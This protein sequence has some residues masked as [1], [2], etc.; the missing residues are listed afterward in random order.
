MRHI[1]DIDIWRGLCATLGTYMCLN[2]RH[3][4][5]IGWPHVSESKHMVTSFATIC[6]CIIHYL[7]PMT[8]SS[9]WYRHICPHLSAMADICVCIIHWCASLLAGSVWY[10][11]I[12]SHTLSLCLA[13]KRVLCT[14]RPAYMNVIHAC[15]PTELRVTITRS[16]YNI[17]NYNMHYW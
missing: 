4:S 2:A 16:R 6:V 13:I 15:V 11:H 17:Y 7:P 3:V 14:A 9:V 5:D 8:H 12:W 10:R 1:Y